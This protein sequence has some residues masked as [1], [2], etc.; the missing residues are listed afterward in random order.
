MSK[1]AQT[2]FAAVYAMIHIFML[3]CCLLYCRVKFFCFFKSLV[4]PAWTTSSQDWVCQ[5]EWYLLLAGLVEGAEGNTLTTLLAQHFAW[6]MLPPQW[7]YRKMS[8]TRDTN[9]ATPSQRQGT[10]DFKQRYIFS[11]LEFIYLIFILVGRKDCSHDKKISAS[12]LEREKN[13]RFEWSSLPKVQANEVF[14]R[15][16][17]TYIT[18]NDGIH[19]T[20]AYCIHRYH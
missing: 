8:L 17:T 7:T 11:V 4:M 1:K 18:D 15:T 3:M 2:D 14:H 12:L 6:N 9:K 13:V 19:F 20:L 10:R 16:T 5:F